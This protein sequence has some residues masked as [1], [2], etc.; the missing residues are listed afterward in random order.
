MLRACRVQ[1]GVTG[2]R[3]AFPGNYSEEASKA[4]AAVLE[5]T[6]VRLAVTSRAW[7]RRRENGRESAGGR[8]TS[9]ETTGEARLTRSLRNRTT[10]RN[11]CQSDQKTAAEA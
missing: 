7:K 3:F 2:K 4:G 10:A 8:E 1:Q 9:R 5:G 6:R 11:S